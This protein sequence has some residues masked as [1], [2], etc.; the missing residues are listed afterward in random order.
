MKRF[1]ATED[2][3][4]LL[5]QRA[6]L[7]LVIWPHGAQ[8]LLGWYGGAGFSGAMSYF[9]EVVHVPAPLAVLVVLAESLGAIALLLGAGSRLAA[10]GIAAT[11]LGALFLVHLPNG[12]F[13][14]WFGNQPGEGFE[15]DLLALALALPIMV[16]GG[17]RAS[18]DGF[19]ADRWLT[20]QPQDSRL[21]TA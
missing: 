12:F 4:Q 16:R 11:M 17:G 15:F 5:L 18:L 19:L 7:A 21:Q 1:L 2:S 3:L 14:N 13:M 20:A 6:V 8:K 10:L 9:T